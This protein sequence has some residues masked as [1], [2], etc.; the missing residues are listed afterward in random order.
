[1]AAISRRS[2]NIW[3]P[4]SPDLNILDYFFWLYAMMQVQMRKPTTIEELKKTIVHV[5]HTIPEMVRDAVANIR[6]RC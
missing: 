6:K 2:E 5:A 4:Y 1:M 3:L